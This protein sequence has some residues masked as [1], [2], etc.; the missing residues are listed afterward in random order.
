MKLVADS[1]ILPA[2]LLITHREKISSKHSTVPLS[3]EEG[4]HH[5]GIFSLALP[6]L[7][8]RLTAFFTA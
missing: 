8:R 4:H 1:M 2:G 7:A 6:Y 3:V 5:E